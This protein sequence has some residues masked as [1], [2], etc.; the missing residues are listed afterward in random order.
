MF[1]VRSVAAAA[2]YHFSFYIVSKDYVC[3]RVQPIGT[4]THTPGY[5]WPSLLFGYAA[6]VSVCVCM[7][8]LCMNHWNLA[9]LEYART[10]F[11]QVGPLETD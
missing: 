1:G 2:A 9:V 6:V 3:V 10:A 11:R 5:R 7:S 4:H 8:I